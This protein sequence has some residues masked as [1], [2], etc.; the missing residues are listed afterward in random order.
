MQSGYCCQKKKMN[1]F[2]SSAI[3]FITAFHPP[4]CF[5]ILLTCFIPISSF[6]GHSLWQDTSMSDSLSVSKRT[7]WARKLQCHTHGYSRQV[8]WQLSRERALCFCIAILQ[9]AS[10]T[11]YLYTE[12]KGRLVSKVHSLHP[13]SESTPNHF[14]GSTLIYF[15]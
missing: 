4:Q 3:W 15:W 11:P 7:A 14:L 5:G 6:C 9:L 1:F 10:K 2:L 8:L 12:H 13:I